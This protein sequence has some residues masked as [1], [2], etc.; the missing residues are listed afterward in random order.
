MILT[1]HQPTYLPWLGLFHKISLADSFVSFNQVQYLTKDWNNRN[2]IKTPQGP[3]WLTVPV[4]SKGY[5]KKKITEIEIN[6]SLPW[7]RQHW[8]SL[9]ANYRR[10]PY[11]QNFSDFFEDVYQREW[12]FLAELDEYMLKWFLK[13]LGIQTRFLDASQFEFQGAKSE[14]V[15][16][17]CRQLRA[18]TCVFGALGKEYVKVEEFETAGIKVVFQDY[19]HP[20]YPQQHGAFVSHLSIVDL[21]FNCGPD[22]LAILKKDQ[23]PLNV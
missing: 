8:R 15:L 17:M 19:N 22:S 12:H 16:D 3:M 5:L 1:G 20:T 6:N 9:L 7:R 13:T 14:L 2:R 4:L 10:S 11:F 21:L 23:I 18:D